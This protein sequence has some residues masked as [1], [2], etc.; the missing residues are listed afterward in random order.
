[1][2]KLLDLIKESLYFNNWRMPSLQQLKQEFHVEQELKKNKF[3]NSE[4]DYLRAMKNAQIVKITPSEDQNIDY[5]SGTQSKEELLNLIKSYK[6]Y[7]E[8]RNEKTIDALY[9]GFEKNQ[10][11]DYPIVLEYDGEKRVFAGNTR[12]DV[13]FQLGINPKVLLI[14]SQNSFW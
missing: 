2:I 10:P 11:M 12:M 14:Q 4:E 13:A 7:P 6:S 1:M 5:R 3:F 8:F 9:N